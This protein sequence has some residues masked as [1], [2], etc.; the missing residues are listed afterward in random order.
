LVLRIVGGTARTTPRRGATLSGVFAT[1]D[2]TVEGRL[3]RVMVSPF[4]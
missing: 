2:F 4:N 3:L 1:C